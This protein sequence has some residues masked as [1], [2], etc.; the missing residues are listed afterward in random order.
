MGHVFMINFVYDAKEG[1]LLN[2]SPRAEY[3][4]DDECQIISGEIL[5]V[6]PK[7]DLEKDP[8]EDGNKQSTISPYHFLIKNALAIQIVGRSA[9]SPVKILFPEHCNS[10]KRDSTM[11]PGSDFLIEFYEKQSF[12][13]Y[14]ENSEGIRTVTGFSRRF[15]FLHE[16]ESR[17]CNPLLFRLNEG[18]EDCGIWTCHGSNFDIFEWEL[19]RIVRNK[20]SY[21]KFTYEIL[22]LFVSPD[23][24]LF[25][26]S[27]P[28]LE[29]VSRDENVVFFDSASKLE[30]VS[31]EGSVVV[32]DK[33]FDVSL[34]QEASK[35]NLL[36]FDNVKDI[37]ETLRIPDALSGVIPLFSGQK[38]GLIN[39]DGIR[40]LVLQDGKPTSLESNDSKHRDLTCI[41]NVS[42]KSE[43]ESVA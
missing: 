12:Y 29:P 13:V 4:N 11:L 27:S 6:N 32:F 38:I 22:N 34:L 31:R 3:F 37:N 18:F 20:Y 43:R 42:V 21:F 23:R 2:D 17:P 33:S 28:K 36:H 10:Y 14:S 41:A 5:C 19:C 16:G 25:I 40:Y 7:K 8:E 30:T 24:Q 15:G 9:D 39:D 26:E 1:H 35:D